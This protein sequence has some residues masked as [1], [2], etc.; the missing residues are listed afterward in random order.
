MCGI[1]GYAGVAGAL[2]RATLAAC[3]DAIWRRG[4]DAAG[5]WTSSDGR[6]AF[7]HRRL[8]IVD[9]SEAGAQPMRSDAGDLAI[10]F[11]G[12]IYNHGALR[13]ELRCL[14]H[15]F[16]GHSDTEVL[17]KAFQQWGTACLSRLRGMF[18]FALYDGAR[19]RLVLARDR[20]G[21]KPLYWA[22]HRQGVMFASE[23]KALFADP[24]FPRELDAN[25]FDAYLAFGYVPH[26]LCLVRGVRKV[27]P[28][29]FAEV[30]LDSGGIRV[31][32]YWHLPA[33]ESCP[34]GDPEELVE[35]L[36][37]LMRDAVSEQLQAD[38][39]VAV[40]LSGGT[41]SSLV[42][43]CAAQVSTHPVQTFSVGFPGAGA[44]DE[45]PHAARVAR[46]FATRHTELE[47]TPASLDLLDEL[48]WHYDEPIADSSMIP[49][50]LLSRL[51]SRHVKAVLGGDGADELFGGYR[52]YQGA[53]R[54]E[55]LRRR[56]PAPARHGI[57]AVSGTVLPPGFPRRNALV[58]LKG[59]AADGVARVGLMFDAAERVGLAP[60]L[61][62]AGMDDSPMHWKRALVEP[63]RGVPGAH[64]A[65]DFQSYL[66][67]DILVKI[68]RASMAHSLEVRAPFL[69]SRIIEFAFGQVPNSLRANDAQRKIL[70]R[71]LARRWLP[72]DFDVDRKQGFS[73]PL[74]DWMTVEH[75]RR[76]CADF[77][78]QFGDVFDFARVRRLLAHQHAGS[79]ARVFG[80]LLLLHWMRAH[81]VAAPGR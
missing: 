25:G 30:S 74:G 37:G 27:P 24:M 7:G 35:R 34:T 48:A 26:D 40:L 57:S 68:D 39:P 1:V 62:T 12:E 50:F 19:R 63:E 14:G 18:A 64:M 69:D 4:P 2:D 67:G 54:L 58:G 6:V 46:H 72:S 78:M 32:R 80:I 28:A 38:V 41:D 79:V 23:L 13:D 44:F 61:R 49:T 36:G 8:A 45:R 60:W 71:R 20:A 9:L 73:V 33:P 70:L 21:E 51:V 16:R 43:A 56:L 52:A 76:A 29:H 59:S 75:R 66:P 5:L 17:L 11:N 42:T 31:E 22:A 10:T 15:A 3:R 65:A 81:R 53:L 47:V 77:E 55:R